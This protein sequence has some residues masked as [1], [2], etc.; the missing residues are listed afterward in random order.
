MSS[1][2]CLAR[3]SY[4]IAPVA[5]A[6]LRADQRYTGFC[7]AQRAL[8]LPPHL[9]QRRETGKVQYPDMVYHRRGGPVASGL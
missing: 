7:E 8:L 5:H 1:E 4:L 6:A 3:F 2:C 9:L